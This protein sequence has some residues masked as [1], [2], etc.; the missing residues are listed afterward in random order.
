MDYDG[1]LDYHNLEVMVVSI[2][3]TRA[4]VYYPNYPNPFNPVTTIRHDLSKESFVG[5]KIYDTFGDVVH[6]FV[7]ANESPG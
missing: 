2:Q 4:I 7:N 6:N 3:N 5:I 1:N